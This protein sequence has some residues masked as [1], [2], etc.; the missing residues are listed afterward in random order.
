VDSLEVMLSR[1][2][3]GELKMELTTGSAPTHGAMP[4]E[5]MVSSELNRETVASTNLSG[6]ALLLLRRF[7]SSNDYQSVLL[8]N[9]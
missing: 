7:R 4:G 5:K 9:G 8:Q 3:V 6:D 2:S 1:L